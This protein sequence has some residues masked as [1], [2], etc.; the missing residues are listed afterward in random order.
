MSEPLLLRYR[1]HRASCAASWAILAFRNQA[2]SFVAGGAIKLPTDVSSLDAEL[3]GLELAVGALLKY[4]RGYTNL[5]PHGSAEILDAS[6][7]LKSNR[8]WLASP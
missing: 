8:H 1:I 4:S 7:L 6:E 2:I 5:V 3:T